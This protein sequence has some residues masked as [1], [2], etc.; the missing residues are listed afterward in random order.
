MNPLL[1]SALVAGLQPGAYRL[2]VD[3][4]IVAQLPVIGEQ[5][6]VTRTISLLD[7]D[8]TGMA[9]ARACRVETTGPGFVTRMPPASLLALPKSQ[10]R[11]ISNGATFT[12]DLGEGRLGYRGNGPLPRAADDQR[13]TDPDGDGAP[14][15]RVLLDLGALGEWTLQIV[16]RGHTTLEGTMTTDGATGRL[17]TVESEEQV[18]SGLPLALPQRTEAIDPR[19]SKFVLQRIPTTAT[20]SFCAWSFAPAAP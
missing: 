10:F 17:S 1:L 4:V 2:D 14:G 16:S 11:L 18:L 6:T 13:V 20:P 3:V 12:A 8:E 7:V 5:R 15:L 19:L 9:T